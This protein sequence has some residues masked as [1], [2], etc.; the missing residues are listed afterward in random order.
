MMSVVAT[1]VSEPTT[2]VATNALDFSFLP[3][4]FIEEMKDKAEH[5]AKYKRCMSVIT[6]GNQPIYC[7][8]YIV[9]YTGSCRLKR[10]LETRKKTIERRLK[11]IYTKTDISNKDWRGPN[12]TDARMYM[13]LLRQLEYT[14]ISRVDGSRGDCVQKG[15]YKYNPI[16][17]YKRRFSYE[18]FVTKQGWERL[19]KE[20]KYL[21]AI[22]KY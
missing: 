14:G 1:A 16:D 12:M 9:D 7:Y 21:M 10:L 17:G 15:K 3:P 5:N 22:V 20:P 19:K 11:D 18:R 8:S 2:V 13:R 4:S 6:S